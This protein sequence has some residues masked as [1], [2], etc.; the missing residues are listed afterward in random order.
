MGK[1]I[2]DIRSYQITEGGAKEVLKKVVGLIG[3]GVLAQQLVIGGY[4]TVIPFLGAII[5]IPM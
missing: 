5:T 1:K 3:L 4:K 2:A